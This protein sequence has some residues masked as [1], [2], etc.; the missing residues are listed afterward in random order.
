MMRSFTL[1]GLLVLGLLVAGCGD[2]SPHTA[3][4]TATKT[5]YPSFIPDITATATSALPS[6]LPPGLS[7]GSLRMFTETEGWAASDT[8][9]FH[10]KD[11]ALHWDNV[12]PKPPGL[13]VA[14]GQHIDNVFF[15]SASQAWVALSNGGGSSLELI[16]RTSTGGASWQQSQ[17]P[18]GH[19][20]TALSFVNI[21]DGWLLDNQGAAA[22]SEA[23]DVYR[24][25][26]GGTTWKKIA[27]ATPD[28]KGAL[29][30]G[31]DKTG[32]SFVSATTGWVTG[33][34]PVENFFWLYR[35]QD[36]GITWKQQA[37][38]LPPN[39]PK[40]QYDL[41]PPV[42]LDGRHGF[43]QASYSTSAG[44][45]GLVLYATQ[46]AGQTWTAA[47]TVPGMAT[48]VNALDAQHLWA[49]DGSVL[50]ASSDGGQTWATLINRDNFKNVGELNFLAPQI[51]FAL[52]VKDGS[53]YVLKTTDGGQTW[54]FVPPVR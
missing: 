40:Q 17:V 22:G 46:N 36:G 24:T 14:G 15:L 54:A 18:S 10:T 38:P 34:E 43:L 45:P 8:Q 13:P 3:S 23:V 1:V 7:I 21:Q 39:Q 5:P 26:D 48:I 53:A 42:F 37:L 32:L 2:T 20:G 9:L 19:T 52:S 6:G 33:A 44:T 29:P 31:G 35:T 30:F 16:F 50:Y 49:T 47:G 51:G 12:T 41:K 25:T 4:G 28:G 11:G 27:S